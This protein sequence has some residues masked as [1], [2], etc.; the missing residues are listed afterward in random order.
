[1]SIHENNNINVSISP[2]PVTDSKLRI[3]ANNSILGV[4]VKDNG[5]RLLRQISG[6]ETNSMQIDLN[7]LRA[8]LYLVEINTMKGLIVRKI[9]IQ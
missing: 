4:L 3:E 9:M 5:G 8:G 6:G 7:G 2:N 1:V